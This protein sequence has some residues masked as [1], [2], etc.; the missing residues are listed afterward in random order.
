MISEDPYDA[1]K[2]INEASSPK[3]KQ[4]DPMKSLKKQPASSRVINQPYLLKMKIKMVQSGMYSAGSKHT[5]HDSNAL[6][7]GGGA[8]L[9]QSSSIQADLRPFSKQSY[10]NRQ[11]SSQTYERNNSASIEFRRLPSK[12]KNQPPQLIISHQANPSYA[13][14]MTANEELAAGSECQVGQ[15]SAFE[16]DREV[17]QQTLIQNKEGSSTARSGVRKLCLADKLIER[18]AEKRKSHQFGDLNHVQVSQNGCKQSQGDQTSMLPLTPLLRHR[19]ERRML[20]LTS[21]AV[22]EFPLVDDATLSGRF[23]HQLNVPQSRNHM[24]TSYSLPRGLVS[25]RKPPRLTSMDSL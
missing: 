12:Y 4:L 17:A 9:N 2:Q 23:K 24:I 21:L 19:S 13:E 3:R 10:F 11:L 22:S 16:G 14:L 1:K 15:R 6:M 25:S 5:L 8:Y 7:K 18:F 20:P